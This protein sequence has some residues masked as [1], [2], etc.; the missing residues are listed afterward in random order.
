MQQFYPQAIPLPVPYDQLTAPSQIQ[1]GTP[2]YL[3]P[4]NLY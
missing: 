2:I 4:V 3:Q 1:L